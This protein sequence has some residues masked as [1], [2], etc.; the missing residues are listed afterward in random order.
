MSKQAGVSSSVLQQQDSAQFAS[1]ALFSGAGLLISLVI[2][3]CR[4]HGIF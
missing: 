3:I 1:I 4:M 2:I